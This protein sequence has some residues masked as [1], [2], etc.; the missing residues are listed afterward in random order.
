[1]TLLDI[2]IGE[3]CNGNKKHQVQHTNILSRLVTDSFLS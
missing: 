1:M 2:L 3:A